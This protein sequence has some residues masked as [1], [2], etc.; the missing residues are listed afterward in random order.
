MLLLVDRK[1]QPSGGHIKMLSTRLHGRCGMAIASPG[2]SRATALYIA[3]RRALFGPS[4]GPPVQNCKAILQ[5]SDG[6]VARIALNF[7]HI[8]LNYPHNRANR[9]Q[10][11]PDRKLRHYQ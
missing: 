3:R 4:E 5:D 2:P 10:G 9:A 8:P 7:G 11:L 1:S 6:P